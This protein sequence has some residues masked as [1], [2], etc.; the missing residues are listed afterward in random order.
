MIRTT[1]AILA[2]ASLAACGGVGQ[3]EF[4]AKST[5]ACVKEQGEAAAAKCACQVKLVEAALNDKEKK[6]VLAT[7]NMESLGPEAGM[8]ALADSGLTIA[9]MMAMGERMQA[10]DTR[11]NAECPA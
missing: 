3:S 11:V 9:D 2:L 8:K 4:A 10:L 6:L 1:A 7:L 5:A